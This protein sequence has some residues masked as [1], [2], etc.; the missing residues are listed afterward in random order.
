MVMYDTV[1][2]DRVYMVLKNAS[3]A[4]PSWEIGK[5]ALCAQ[6]TTIKNIKFLRDAGCDINDH[7]VTKNGKRYKEY[8]IL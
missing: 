3:R 7:Y 6:N 1:S 8:W 5:R 4:L 2:M